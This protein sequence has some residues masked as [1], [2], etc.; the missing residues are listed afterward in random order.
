MISLSISRIS[1]PPPVSTI[2]RSATSPA[3]SGGV[4]SSAIF[5]A[6]MMP[7]SGSCKASR[8]SLLLRVKLR[9]T[10]SARLRPLISISRTSEAG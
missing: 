10:P 6:L 3:N 4:V 2:P 1:A 9:G 7:D 5:T 8:I